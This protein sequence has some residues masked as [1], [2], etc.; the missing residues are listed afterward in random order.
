MCLSMCVNMCQCVCVMYVRPCF[1]DGNQSKR[2]CTFFVIKSSSSFFAGHWLFAV[3]HCLR[4]LPVVVSTSLSPPISLLLHFFDLMYVT[5]YMIRCCLVAS[6][7]SARR[8]AANQ[9]R[10]AYEKEQVTTKTRE[11][12]IYNKIFINSISVN[13]FESLKILVFLFIFYVTTIFTIR[14]C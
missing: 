8:R 9:D 4:Y 6:W 11:N 10:V 14:K 13:I 2:V 7:C 3:V 12:K 5:L 1:K